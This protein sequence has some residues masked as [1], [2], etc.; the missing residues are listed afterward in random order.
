MSSKSSMS[1]STENTFVGFPT[2][3][4]ANPPTP[5]PPA[6]G[7]DRT[8][9]GRFDT[10]GD[11]VLVQDDGGGPRFTSDM[12]AQLRARLRA[13]EQAEEAEASGVFQRTPEN[14]LAPVLSESPAQELSGVSEIAPMLPEPVA[15]EPVAAEPV[16]AEPGGAETLESAEI[17]ID[18]PRAEP[19]PI[20][21]DLMSSFGALSPAVADSLLADIAPPAVSTLDALVAAVPEIEASLAPNSESNFYSGFDEEHPDGVF[22]ATYE[23]LSVGTPVYIEVLLPAGYRFR[24]PATVEWVREMSDDPELPCGMGLRMCGLDESMRRL[25][26]TYA[27]HRKPLFW[28][29]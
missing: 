22:V 6:A 12:M 28:V 10:S 13:A 18:M 8:L 1:S 3:P 4:V 17:A 29:G 26:R 9:L 2:R 19:E 16:A 24:T 25:I 20:S 14:G 27:R 5:R 23:S 21:P 15:V 7:H 11:R